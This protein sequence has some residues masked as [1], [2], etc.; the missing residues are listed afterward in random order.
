MRAVEALYKAGIRTVEFTNRGEEALKVFEFLKVQAEKD[1]PHLLLGI[2]TIK[3]MGAARSF[4]GAGADYIIS[5]S[6]NP[7]VATVT[8]QAGLEWIPG[9][10]TPTEIA[11]AEAN[12]AKLVKLFPGNVLGPDFVAAVKA[13]FPDLYFM[14]TGGVETETSN[15]KAWFKSGVSAVGMGS[16]LVSKELLEGR[17]YDELEARTREVLQLIRKV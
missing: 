1:F 11:T 15:L 12:G 8:H 13:V 17:K 16:K 9:C 14:P 7:D 3:D 6:T 5:P 4:I 10:M 2:G